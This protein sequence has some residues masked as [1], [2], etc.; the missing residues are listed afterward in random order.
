M[1][2]WLS[3]WRLGRGAAGGI[4]SVVEVPGWVRGLG[5]TREGFTAPISGPVTL[6]FHCAGPWCGGILPG[7]DVLMF[8]E[9][10]NDGDRLDIGLCRPMAFAEPS[11]AVL[12]AMQSCLAGHCP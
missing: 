10:G 12:H 1:A 8:L 7:K 9:R 4:R 5:L 2:N 3:T 11:A 6:R